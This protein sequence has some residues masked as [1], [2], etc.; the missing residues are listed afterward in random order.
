MKVALTGHRPEILK[1]QE[2]KVFNWISCVIE[3]LFEGHAEREVLCGMARGADVIFGQAAL[4][5]GNSALHLCLP[6]RHYG[7]LNADRDYWELMDNAAEITYMQDKWS[8]GCDD[9]RDRYMVDNCDVLLAVWDGIP[10]GGVWST[11]QYAVEKGK[12]IIYINREIFK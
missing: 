8:K 12:P 5:S 10:A 1:G 9:K 4:K 6:C 11:I 3:I 2:S 7:E